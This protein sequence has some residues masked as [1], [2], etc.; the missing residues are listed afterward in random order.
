MALEKCKAISY[1]RWVGIYILRGFGN[2]EIDSYN[3]KLAKEIFSNLK[4]Y[5]N[6]LNKWIEEIN[7]KVK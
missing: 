3:E 7:K 5:Y 6:I 4:L 2:Y 1:E